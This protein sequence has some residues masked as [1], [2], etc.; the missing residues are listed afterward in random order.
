MRERGNPTDGSGEEKKRP[1]RWFSRRRIDH[2]AADLIPKP[3]EVEERPFGGQSHG[4]SEPGLHPKNDDSF[5]TGKFHFADIAEPGAPDDAKYEALATALESVITINPQTGKKE[6]L[7]ITADSIKELETTVQT[8]KDEGRLGGL[9]IIADGV[10]GRSNGEYASS[11]VQYG[12]VR[13]IAGD[14]IHGK[15]IDDDTVRKAMKDAHALLV[16]Y[17]CADETR[18]SM[19]TCVMALTTSDGTTYVGSVGDSR[20]YKQDSDGNV[21]RITSDDSLV[22]Q[23]ALTGQKN[24]MGN[25][26]PFRYVETF[27]DPQKNRVTGFLGGRNPDVIE[28]DAIPV[29]AVVMNSGEKII[30]VSDGSWEGIDTND[31]DTQNVLLDADARYTFAKECGI[32]SSDAKNIADGKVFKELNLK[33]TDG[34]SSEELSKHLT[35]PDVQLSSG[36]NVTAVVIE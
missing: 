2:D 19:T 27:I 33:D 18:E 13:S 24:D 28:A 20:A 15:Q 12:I 31:P 17:N 3:K 26:S 36:D 23:W 32:P 10:G 5:F 22:E 6:T 29:H 21:T 25:T 16:D 1:G 30:L 9:D 8:V 7:S 11:I 4:A 14:I 34:M 35:R